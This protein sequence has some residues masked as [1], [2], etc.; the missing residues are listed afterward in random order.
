MQVQM[1]KKEFDRLP[2]IQQQAILMMNP[3]LRKKLLLHLKKTYLDA[4]TWTP[5]YENSFG[6]FR[7]GQNTIIREILLKLRRAKNE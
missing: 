2:K 1:T 4:P 3:L 5:G 6:Y 7:D